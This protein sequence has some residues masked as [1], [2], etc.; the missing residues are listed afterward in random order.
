MPSPVDLALVLAVDVSASVDL[1]EFA[2]MVEGLGSALED[3]SVL[4]AFTSGPAG[5]VAVA[6]MFWSEP[7][8][9][10]IA[11]P[12]TRIADG[13]AAAEMAGLVRTAPRP[14]RPGRTAIGAA[15]LAAGRLLATCPFPARRLVV[16]VSGDGRQNAGPALAPAR[17]ALLDAGI[18]I[19]GL[20]VANEEPDLAAWYAANLI[21]GPGAFAMETPDY[22]AF[23]Q[24]MR[25][26]LL[27]EAR[28]VP[29]AW[30]GGHLAPATPRSAR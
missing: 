2:L 24:A 3:A 12:W 11:A 10:E 7:T 27:R 1:D 6:C 5:A 25:E 8:G 18:T 9:H 23:A 20:A 22:A 13:G 26:K 30:A 15:L 29:I 16:D 4:R 14:A 19:N 28:G 17:L 21:G